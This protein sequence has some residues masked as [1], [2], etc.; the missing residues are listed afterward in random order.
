MRLITSTEDI[1]KA[2]WL[3]LL[4]SSPYASPFQSPEMYELCRDT[5]GM[6]PCILAVEE[7]DSLKALM[8]IIIH[9]EP[10]VKAYFTRRGI[11]YSGPLLAEGADRVALALLLSH[12]KTLLKRKV[13]Y[14]ELRNGFDFSTLKSV[15]ERASLSYVP[16]LN[17][18]FYQVGRDDF[19]SRISKSKWRQLNKALQ[20]GVEWRISRSEDDVR[21]FYAILSQLYQHK[22]RKPIPSFSFFIEM[23]QSTIAQLL[24]VEYRGHVIGG[25]LC[26]YSE[27]GTLY[28]YYIC[29]LDREY[30]DCSPSTVAMWAMVCFAED[31]GVKKIDLMGA[32][33]ADKANSVREY[34]RSFGGVL[35]EHGRYL[36]ILNLWRYRL[37]RFVINLIKCINSHYLVKRLL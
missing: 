27:G 14:L 19:K 4:Q 36:M 8:L 6:E 35:V 23:V 31:S 24:V 10:G 17:Y 1:D 16:W 29:G 30:P 22:V 5:A 25:V 33:Q 15:F 26:P 2:K 20:K 18:Q 7:G 11:V 37:G 21:A 9:Y 34:K 28:E 3:Q 13:I 32:G 12:L